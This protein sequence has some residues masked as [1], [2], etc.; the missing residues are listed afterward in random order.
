MK[1]TF[2]GIYNGERYELQGPGAT[3]I[4]GAF[5]SFVHRTD[6]DAI[7]AAQR[8][9]KWVLV[10]DGSSFNH[11]FDAI[12]IRVDRRLIAEVCGTGLYRYSRWP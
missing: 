3:D 11:Y 9:L 4:H 8:I 5:V 10:P 6:Y 12:E 7:G 2:I 1:F